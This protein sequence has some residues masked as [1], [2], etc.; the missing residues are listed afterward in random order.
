MTTNT[1]LDEVVE[2][3]NRD[4]DD[5][6]DGSAVAVHYNRCNDLAKRQTRVE[7]SFIFCSL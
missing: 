3:S 1:Y 6:E 7:V 2:G 5:H 4:N